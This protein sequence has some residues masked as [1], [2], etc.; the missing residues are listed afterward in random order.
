MPR[1][2][3]KAL[4]TFI[5]LAALAGCV[6]RREMTARHQAA[7]AS[8]GFQPGTEGYAN[9]LLQLDMGDYSYGHHGGGVPLFPARHPS[10]RPAPAPAVTPDQAR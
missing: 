8:Y 9:C 6:S 7:C 2:L 10:P 3:R 1:P 5:L 4:S